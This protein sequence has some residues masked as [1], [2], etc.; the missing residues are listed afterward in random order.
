[1]TI[2]E[3]QNVNPIV[4]NQSN[5]HRKRT[6]WEN[7]SDHQSIEKMR[8]TP[9]PASIIRMGIL[10]QFI[11]IKSKNSV[12]Q[13]IKARDHCQAI[14]TEWK[15]QFSKDDKP[16]VVGVYNPNWQAWPVSSPPRDSS[17]ALLSIRKRCCRRWR[18]L[19]HILWF[20]HPILLEWFEQH[21]R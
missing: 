4:W 17:D 1:M 9:P 16:T 11:W 3:F 13:E 7:A 21:E 6:H 5:Q 14:Q 15:L 12:P 19:L 2:E 20:T 10:D 8:K 18:M